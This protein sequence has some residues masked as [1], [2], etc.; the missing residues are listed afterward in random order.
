MNLQSYNS[1][2]D[3]V[4]CRCTAPPRTVVEVAQSA[5]LPGVWRVFLTAGMG[6]LL[7]GAWPDA[8]AVSGGTVSV[9]WQQ[10]DTQPPSP[11]NAP[12][13]TEADLA[14]A[15]EIPVIDREPFDRLHFDDQQF[16]VLDVNPLELDGIDRN[17]PVD[18]TG[19][20]G[21]LVFTIPD[22]PGR[23]FA[24]PWSAL[25][26]IERYSDLVLAEA[27]E[28][29]EQKDWNTAFRTLVF[30]SNEA[31]LGRT[32]EL[33]Q[34]LD[35]CLYLDGVQHLEAGD[36]A[37]ALSAF[38]GLYERNPQYRTGGS[39]SVLDNIINCYQQFVEKE[40]D[41]GDFQ[42]VR[43][44]LR[45]MR[46]VY[47]ERVDPIAADWDKKMLEHALRQLG[48][49]RQAVAAGQAFDAHLAVRQVL[50]TMPD[51]P[52]AVAAFN[53]VVQQFPMVLV[54]VT[55]FSSDRDPF[56]IENW[57]SRRLGRLLNRTIM[58]F[59]KPGDDGGKYQ[60]PSGR[61]QQIDE[62][63]LKF[64]FTLATDP[65]A[66]VPEL[67]AYELSNR[68]M[69]LADPDSPDYY[70]PWARMIVG[71]EIENARSVVI[72][73][74]YPHVRPESLMPLGYFAADDPRRDEWFG[75]YRP[76]GA[77]RTRA[78]PGDRT[79]AT[80]TRS[81]A[82]SRRPGIG[83]ATSLI[84]GTRV[85]TASYRSSSNGCFPTRRRPWTPCCA[86]NWMWSIASIRRTFPDSGVTRLLRWNP[87]SSR[88]SIC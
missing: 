59:Q 68:L 29:M 46:Q 58:E 78:T 85:L 13:A 88:W 6:L 42:G 54:G 14:D 39:G 1:L 31:D 7:V 52:A 80:R 76:A 77:T 44:L 81:R 35:Q 40:F 66:G 69:D 33:N 47:G 86:G 3:P 2:A 36:F 23:V 12:F 11:G 27:R 74:R 37:D 43:D 56:R 38:E 5:R 18:P 20:Q 10:D 55:Q 73:M 64:R 61:F 28:A 67:T 19:K 71:I 65:S 51:L 32:A 53:E 84:R 16:P 87:I 50:Y 8:A 26:K 24:T 70:I 17:Q 9:V 30:L 72:R 15:P 48:E 62:L 41:K 4:P 82:T 22:Y 79:R 63:G 34:M 49:V 57:A 75:L 83:R 21:R 60:F 45:A 25:V